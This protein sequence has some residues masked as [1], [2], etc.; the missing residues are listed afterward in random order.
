MVT[1]AQSAFTEGRWSAP[2]AATAQHVTRLEEGAGAREVCGVHNDAVSAGVAAAAWRAVPRLRLRS[3]PVAAAR[4]EV[5]V[6]AA[7]VGTGLLPPRSQ[8][9]VLHALRILE[10]NDKRGSW[11]NAACA[12]EQLQS[13]VPG[14][15]ELRKLRLALCSQ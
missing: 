2:F 15:P 8:P 7:Q 14:R 1:H 11:P 13:A 6:W 10:T 5:D 9:S 4:A 12:V 3:Q